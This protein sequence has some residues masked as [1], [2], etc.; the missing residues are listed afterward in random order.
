MVRWNVAT[1]Y[2][3]TGEEIYPTIVKTPS[4]FVHFDNLENTKE[5]GIRQTEPRF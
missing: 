3:E 4:G 2:A 1:F 5:D